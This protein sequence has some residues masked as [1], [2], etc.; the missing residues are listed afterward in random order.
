MVRNVSACFIKPPPLL[1]LTNV[2]IVSNCRNV[3]M[4]ETKAYQIRREAE[5]VTNLIGRRLE[6]ELSRFLALVSSNFLSSFSWF[7]VSFFLS[8]DFSKA[9]FCVSP[10]PP[11]L[12]RFFVVC[13]LP[14]SCLQTSAAAP[15]HVSLSP[16]SL[17]RLSLSVEL[18]N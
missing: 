12:S 11:L 17:H 7:T 2:N 13:F 15:C 1:V 14:S 6:M 18:L 5:G 9:H 3:S 10:L 4:V 16:P 8:Y